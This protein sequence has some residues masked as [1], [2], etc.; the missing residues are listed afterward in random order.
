VT[1]HRLKVAAIQMN[2]V[3]GNKKKNLEKLEGLIRHAA[4]EEAELVVVPELFNTGYR[5]ETD[6]IELGETIPGDS[7]DWMVSL[8]N[9][10][11]LTIVGC[12]LEKDKTKGVVFDTSVVTNRCGIVGTYRKTHLWDKENIRF[13]KGDSM[14]IVPLEWGNLGMQICYE[15]GIPEGARV[16]ALNGADVLAYPSAFGRARLYAWDIATRARAL[17]NG[18]YLVAAN[19]SGIERGETVFAGHSRIVAPTGEILAEATKED[20]VITAEID[21]IKVIEQRRALPYLRDLNKSFY[22]KELEKA[23]TNIQRER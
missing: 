7:T 15:I 19:R 1:L 3:L 9:E 10:L 18:C 8:S 11:N 17:E 23:I 6:D 22:I 2:C 5:V 21:L 16:M 4:Q 13:A 12:I 20:E 14:P